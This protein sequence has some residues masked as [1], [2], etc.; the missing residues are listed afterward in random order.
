[1]DRDR[2]IQRP[3]S[4]FQKVDQ[5][6]GKLDRVMAPRTL[7]INEFRGIEGAVTRAPARLP[8]WVRAWGQSVLRLVVDHHPVDQPSPEVG[9]EGALVLQTVV[10]VGFARL[11]GDIAYVDFERPTGA[12]GG[13][14][15]RDEQVG[16]DAG[17]QTARADDDHVGVQNGVNRLRERRRVVWLEVY[18][19]D[20]SRNL[21]DQALAFD[22]D[23][24]RLK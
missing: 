14:D 16:Q 5:G 1:M 8:D 9:I 20:P 4:L 22:A 15:F 18:L 12:D 24:P 11:G 10:A 19:P 23:S 6:S 7:L 21:G 13:R 3:C 17:I 2:V